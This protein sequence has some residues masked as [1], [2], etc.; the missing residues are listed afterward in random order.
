MRPG[1]TYP[2]LVEYMLEEYPDAKTIGFAGPDVAWSKICYDGLTYAIEKSPSGVELAP[3]V[4]FPMFTPDAS[5]YVAELLSYN[6]DIIH[7]STW[8]IAGLGREITAL[9]E[10]GFDVANRHFGSSCAVCP[11]AKLIDALGEDVE[12]I[13]GTHY[14]APAYRWD[15]TTADFNWPAEW[16]G[17]GPANANNEAYVTEFI[18]RA[19]FVPELLQSGPYDELMYVAAVFDYVGSTDASVDEYI[20]ALP[21]VDYIPLCG[22]ATITELGQ[23]VYTNLPIVRVI[24]G[25]C[26]VVAMPELHVEDILSPEDYARFFEE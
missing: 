7:V 25:K 5:A 26:T 13:R 21:N 24:D 1:L 19:G 3:W 23:V 18:R 22:K 10:Q 2:A 4:R 16:Q 17:K 14:Y 20:A 15:D 11:F 8:D 9:K 6:P 12:G